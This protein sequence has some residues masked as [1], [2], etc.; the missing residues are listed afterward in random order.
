MHWVIDDIPTTNI[1]FT[2]N[3]RDKSEQLV[4]RI[5]RRPNGNVGLGNIVLMKLV[6]LLLQEALQGLCCRVT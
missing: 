6:G 5:P 1:D 4:S 2:G 3:E